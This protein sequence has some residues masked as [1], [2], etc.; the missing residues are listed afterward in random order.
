L[1]KKFAVRVNSDWREPVNLYLLVVADPSEKKSPCF[2]LMNFSVQ[3]YEERWNRDHRTE[4]E[5]GKEKKA[6]LVKARE[7]AKNKLAR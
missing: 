4:I 7:N 2:K 5:T 1:Q 6:A 3:E